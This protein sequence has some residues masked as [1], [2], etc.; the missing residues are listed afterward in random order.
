[1]FSCITSKFWKTLNSKN[2]VTQKSISELFDLSGKTA[3][4][5]GGAMGIGYGIVKR[6]AEAGAS[7]VIA[8]LDEKIGTNKAKNLGDK[9]MFVK[10]DVSSE[11]DVKYL[12]ETTV[13][14]FG[15]LDIMINNAGIFPQKKVTEMDVALWDKIQAVNMRGV[16]LGCREAAL[17]MTQKGGVI[18]N[19]AS[20]DARH[21]SMVGLA[22][23]D[24]SKHGV[25]GF[26]KNFA[27]E[28]AK[29]GIRVNAIAPGGIA[30]EGVA[31]MSEGADKKQMTEQIKVFT[32][33]IP[34]GRF[35]EPDD[36]ATAALFLCSDASAYMTGA[37]VI[38]DGGVLLT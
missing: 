23:Y 6:L 21:P 1:M 38:V 16:F 10:T 4:V 28:V 18:I 26:T 17:A 25:W 7:V 8:D 13:K 36:I 24:A 14:K 32:A 37:M 11:K 30:T 27:L 19:I 5:T 31:K 29:Q 15:A 20:I 34:L 9:G 22:A 2:T 12:V 35:G 3:I 33:K